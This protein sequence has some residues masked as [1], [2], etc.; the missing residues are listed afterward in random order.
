MATTEEQLALRRRR[1]YWVKRARERKGYTLKQVAHHLGYSENS[2]SSPSLWERGQRAIPSDQM[3]RLASFLSL[4]GTFLVHPPL[5]D[6]E[7]LEAA[8]RESAALERQD[9]EQ[10]EEGGPEAEDEPDAWRD[11]RSA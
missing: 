1:G 3:G 5:T 4:P 10:G 11:R 6:D 8:V 7:R 2:I 9:W